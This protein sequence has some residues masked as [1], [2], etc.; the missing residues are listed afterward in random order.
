MSGAAVSNSVDFR[1]ADVLR[2]VA[3]LPGEF[4]IKAEHRL[5]ADLDIDSLKLIDVMVRLEQDMQIDLGD[6]F[7]T[8]VETVA[9][10]GAYIS[11]QAL[12]Q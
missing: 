10:L 12:Q 2:Q 6:G 7:E 9:Q 1:V 4:E 5:R 11:K 3:E 8:G